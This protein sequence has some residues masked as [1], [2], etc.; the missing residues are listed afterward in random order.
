MLINKRRALAGDQLPL[1]NR[2]KR[3]FTDFH[4][5]VEEIDILHEIDRILVG[6]HFVNV[7]VIRMVQQDIQLGHL[8]DNFEQLAVVD[9]LRVLGKHN[10]QPHA[11][12]VV[13]ELPK[14]HDAVLLH[15][16]I[17]VVRYVDLLQVDEQLVKNRFPQDILAFLVQNP[18][19]IREVA[20]RPVLTRVE[21]AVI[22]SWYPCLA[23]HVYN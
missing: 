1:I 10:C 3:P 2:E 20:M 5:R 23:A 6:T 7:A 18:L 19:F 16:V 12:D 11:L 21:T 9:G 4:N 15:E 22:Q 8:Q 13:E 14:E 17:A